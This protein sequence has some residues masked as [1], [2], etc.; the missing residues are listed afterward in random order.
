VIPLTD[1]EL[2][3]LVRDAIAR[4]RANPSGVPLPGRP[5]SVPAAPASVQTAGVSAHA[6]DAPSAPAIGHVHASQAIFILG[7]GGDADGNCVIEPAVRCNHCGYCQSY[8]H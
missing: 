8:G 4:V 5:A 7:P 6:D 3:G 2:R 1:D